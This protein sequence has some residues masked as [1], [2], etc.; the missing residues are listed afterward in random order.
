MRTRLFFILLFISYLAFPQARVKPTSEK[1]VEPDCLEAVP[2]IINTS[3]VYGPTIS[4]DGFGK[5]QEIKKGNHLLFDGEHNS[6]WYLLTITRNGELIFEV[7][8]TDTTNDYDFLL[9]QYADSNFCNALMNNKLTPVRSNLS[10]ITRSQKGITG[11]RSNETNKSVGKGSGNANSG[12]VMVKKNEKYMLILDNVT[13][14]GKGH[15]ICFNFVKDVEINGNVV[16]SDNLPVVA[17]ITLSDNKGIVILETKSDKNGDY[18]IKSVLRENQNYN[19]SIISDSTFVQSQIINTNVLKGKT[20]FSTIKVVLPKLKKGEKYKLGNINFFGNLP[21]IIPASI[22]SVE[23]L[24]KLM[25]MNKKMIIQIE[26]H[27]NDP[28]GN[29][30]DIFN[31]ILSRNRAKTIYDYLI[32]KGI[33]SERLGYVGLSNKFPLF[34]RP[35]NDLQKQANRRVEIK[36]IS[37]E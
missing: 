15:T 26:G 30:D 21:T 33:S 20:V 9:Y 12:S 18:K 37:L 16:N 4:P 10:N 25:K 27:V 29:S 36:V 28:G 14:Q 1:T 13:S 19:L 8:P 23:S 31:E 11:L 24:Y 17:D 2:I 35:I 5:V 34:K 7:Q 6:A 32:N 22:P 3:S